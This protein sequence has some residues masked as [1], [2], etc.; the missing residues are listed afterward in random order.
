MKSIFKS[1]TLIVI[2]VSSLSSCTEPNLK[3]QVIGKWDYQIYIDAQKA[4]TI[5]G[6]EDGVEMEMTADLSV[7]YMRGN[8]YNSEGDVGVRVKANGQEI[9]MKF[10]V[11]ETGSWEI[12]DNY[13]ISIVEGSKFTPADEGTRKLVKNTPGLAESLAP[14]KG[15]SVSTE[16]KEISDKSMQVEIDNLPGLI[17]THHKK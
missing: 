17:I 15:E 14:V 13:I 12:H 11:T 6:S 2:I 10:R 8:R 3:D 5:F 4:K 7:N 9:P 1:L 16:I